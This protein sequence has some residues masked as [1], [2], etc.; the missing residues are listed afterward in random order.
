MVDLSAAVENAIAKLR[1]GLVQEADDLLADVLG[2]HKTEQ[3]AAGIM[4][5]PL[6]PTAR[7]T[8]CAI[9]DALCKRAGSP[10]DLE[11]LIQQFSRLE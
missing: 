2:K 9:L 5:P 10:P 3:V 11:A 6:P 1:S 8:L 7:Q 4:P